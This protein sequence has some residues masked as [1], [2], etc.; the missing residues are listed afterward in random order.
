VMK[1]I[2]GADLVQRV[3]RASEWTSTP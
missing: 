2:F 1:G 3:R